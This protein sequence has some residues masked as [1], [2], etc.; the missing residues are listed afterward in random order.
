MP[1]PNAD[2]HSARPMTLGGVAVA[3]VVLLTA[4]V[5]V[6]LGRGADSSQSLGSGV[7]ITGA[8]GDQTGT[9]TSPPLR[10]DGRLPAGKVTWPS[11]AFSGPTLADHKEFGQWRGRKIDTALYFAA[12]ETWE[13]MENPAYLTSQYAMD[14]SITP[15]ISYA[16]WPV[17]ERGGLGQDATPVEIGKAVYPMAAAGAFD[18]HWVTLAENLIAQGLPDAIIRPGWEFNGNW[19]RWSATGDTGA[20]QFAEY[21]RRIVTA[22][23][24]VPGADFRFT[25][26]PVQANGGLD[27]AKA[28][29]GD[30]FVD[31]I[32]F[33]VYNTIFKAGAD[34]D[35]QWEL[36]KGIKYGLEW[37]LSFA[38][39][40]DKPISFPEWAGYLSPTN[41]RGSGGD[42]TNFIREMFAWMVKHP[43]AYE[44]YFDYDGGDGVNYG[45]HTETSKLGRSAETYKALWGRK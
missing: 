31:S 45:I 40:H 7:P 25:W 37:Q 15:V 38:N 32:G 9:A 11:G 33:D 41:P 26:C 30:A 19:Y 35:E 29:P 6:A 23:R 22:M 14:P 44:N 36:I 12:Q 21:F 20:R 4:F 13:A 10:S 2:R 3:L 27:L 16:L 28:Y 42:D 39:K 1:H 17:T 5:V 18:E 8:R 34:Q 24:S 43:P